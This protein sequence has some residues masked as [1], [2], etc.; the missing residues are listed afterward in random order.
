MEKQMNIVAWKQITDA[1]KNCI[2]KLQVE[3]TMSSR[4]KKKVFAELKGWTE[5]GNGWNDK[6]EICLFSRSFQSKD[7]FIKWAKQFPFE[8]K[9]VNRNGKEKKIN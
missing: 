4:D 7:S 3:G 1:N 2:Y 6:K 9:E 5:V 8:L